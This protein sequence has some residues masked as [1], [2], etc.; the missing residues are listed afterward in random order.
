MPGKLTLNRIQ[1]LCHHT[2]GSA[3]GRLLFQSRDHSLIKLSTFA[4]GSSPFEDSAC[5]AEVTRDASCD[6]SYPASERGTCESRNCSSSMECNNEASQAPTS[7]SMS[8]EQETSPN[9]FE[10][11]ATVSASLA[12]DNLNA[13]F[14]TVSRYTHSADTSTDHTIE[15]GLF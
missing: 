5:I 13:N 1:H 6:N 10:L 14:K 4:K 8:K 15:D 9:C 3:R 12:S 2:P 7:S 11:H